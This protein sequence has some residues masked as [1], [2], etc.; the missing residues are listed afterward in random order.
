LRKETLVDHVGHLPVRTFTFVAPPAPPSWD[1]M[2]VNLSEGEVVKV[3]TD[4]KKP[5]SYSISAKREESREFDL[6]VKIYPAGRVSG[7]LDELEPGE[8]VNIWKKPSWKVKQ[9][10][11]HLGIVAFGVGITEAVPVAEAHLE[12]PDTQVTLLWAS[13]SMADTFWE[14]RLSAVKAAHGQRFKL[15]H[16]LS[17]ERMH[18]A[19][20]GR[21]SSSMMQ[22][23]FLDHWGLKEDDEHN[24]RF[25]TVGTKEMMREAEEMLADLGFP[26]PAHALICRADH[27]QEMVSGGHSPTATLSM[28]AHGPKRARLGVE[29]DS[30]QAQAV[31]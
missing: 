2:Q 23:V 25:L 1:P 29:G 14:D 15:V 3:E 24:V 11:S 10:C 8:S 18:G 9:S 22:E 17:R 27:V 21:V 7:L 28:P 12:I 31:L 26:F 13:R 19:M 16:A 6:T 20:H 5:T 30:V 4:V